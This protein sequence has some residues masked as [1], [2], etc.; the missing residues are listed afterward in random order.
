MNEK[1]ETEL[2]AALKFIG[3]MEYSEPVYWECRPELRWHADLVQMPPKLQQ[4]WRS[5]RGQIEWRDLP[6]HVGTE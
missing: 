1:T 4:A 2:G 3:S 5:S 6:L